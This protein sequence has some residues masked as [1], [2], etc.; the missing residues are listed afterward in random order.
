MRQLCVTAAVL[1][2][3][4]STSAVIRAEEKVEVK[5]VHLCCNNCVKSVAGILKKVEGVADAK[6]DRATK[7]VTFTAKDAE[8]A[9]KAVESL[10][11]GG[12]FGSATCDGKALK[13]KVEVGLPPKGKVNTVTVNDVHV[14]CNSCRKAI[15]KLFPGATITYEGKGAQRNVTIAADNLEPDTVLR[16]LNVAGFHGTFGKK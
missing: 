14:C 2:L 16:T 1:L 6:C 9:Q 3:A 11:R 13:F 4:G 15:Q 8:T 12:F 5:G 10:T 7:T